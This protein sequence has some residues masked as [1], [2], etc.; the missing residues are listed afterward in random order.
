M[1]VLRARDMSCSSISERTPQCRILN[2]DHGV[3]SLEGKLDVLRRCSK[4]FD[5]VKESAPVGL[6][7]DRGGRDYERSESEEFTL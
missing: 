2:S 5:F 6:G 1:D 4:S 7:K 3:R